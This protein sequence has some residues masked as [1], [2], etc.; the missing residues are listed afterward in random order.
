MFRT[1][2][3]YSCVLNHSMYVSLEETVNNLLQVKLKQNY[4]SV[5]KGG[6]IRV[7]VPYEIQ[8]KKLK[9]EVVSILKQSF[10]IIIIILAGHN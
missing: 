2:R 7:R 1:M 10:E 9:L 5:L 6:K 4:S 8:C 3:I